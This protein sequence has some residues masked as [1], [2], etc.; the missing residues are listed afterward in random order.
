MLDL[1]IPYIL[2]ACIGAVAGVAAGLLGVGGGTII[3]PAL[4]ATFSFFSPSQPYPMQTAIGTSLASIIFSSL[5]SALSYKKRNSVALEIVKKMSSGVFLGCCVGGFLAHLISGSFL[6]GT[7]GL[8][9]LA[10]ALRFFFSKPHYSSNEGGVDKK[11]MGP[12]A[13]FLSFI[14]SLLGIGGGVLF[15]PYLHFLKIS[16]IKAIGT[17]SALSAKVSFFGA[18]FYIL[19]GLFNIPISITEVGFIY[20]PAF[21]TLSIFSF[22]TAPLGV[23]LAHILPQNISRKLFACSMFTAG[24][25]MIFG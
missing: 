22:L 13:F 9:A 10:I 5:S 24:L 2:Y 14:S 8:F 6:K 15:I 12:P 7:F 18:L 11:T 1:W 23:K 3:V 21:L 17:S 25:F 20:V 19:F 4:Y 16:H